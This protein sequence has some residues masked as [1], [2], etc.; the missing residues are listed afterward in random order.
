MDLE[1]QLTLSER[2]ARSKLISSHGRPLFP[3]AVIV[4]ALLAFMAPQARAQISPGPLAK[5]H[6]PLSGTTQCNTCH[7]FGTK[8]PTYKCLDCHKEVAQR[9]AAKHGYHSQIQMKN[10]NGKECVRCHLDHNGENFT[11]IHWE[12]SQKQFDHRLTGYKLEG[13][14]DGLACEKCHAEAYMVAAEKSLIKMKNI[15]K[16][17]FAMRQDCVACHKDEHN[18]R[19]GNNCLKCHNFEDWKSAKN[20]DHSKTR[21]PLTGEHIQVKCEKCHKPDVPG[22]PS[23]YSD[24]KFGAC[25]DCHVDPH[26]GSFKPKRCE[27]CHTTAGW[28]KLLPGFEFDHSKTKY[29]LLGKHATVACTDCHKSGDFKKQLLFEKC[30]DCHKPDPHKGQFEK[31]ARKGECEECHKVEGWKPSL[32]GVKEHDTSGYPLKGKHGKVE[33]DKCHLPAGKDTIYKVKY[34]ACLDCHKDPHDGQFAGDPHKNRCEDCHTVKDFHQTTFTVAMHKK[35]KFILAG[36]HTAVPCSDCHKVGLAGRTDKILPFHFADMA[37]TACH[38]DVHNG[39]FKDRMAKPRADGTPFGCEACHTMRSWVDVTGFDHSKTKF[40]LLGAHRV[41]KCSECH[42]IPVGEKKVK[43]EG[44]SIICEDCH[45]DAHDKQFEKEG[46]THCGDCHNSFR[47]VPSIFDHDK[48]THFPLQGGHAGVPC[49]KCHTQSHIVDGKPVII[50]RGAPIEC[51]SCHGANIVPLLPGPNQKPSA[52]KKPL[53]P[54]SLNSW[55]RWELVESCPGSP[56]I[57]LSCSK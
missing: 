46:K 52:D 39:E 33:C 47:W 3:V 32:F 5:A 2:A 56:G 54:P 35:T 48:R 20:F 37:C 41:V 34:G 24:M 19:L 51:A 13:K 28:K 49:E 40:P 42:K 43:F 38:K 12:P 8:E 57:K 30:A 15:S 1:I 29:P 4:A 7:V 45:R 22:G 23:R 10:P 21:Y 53:P 55:N 6:Q 9:L 26:K 27:D 11:L 31:R 18:G 14:H 44:T 50:Y 17:F 36:A 16:S 25:I